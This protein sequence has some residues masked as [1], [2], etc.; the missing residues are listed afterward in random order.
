M[1]KDL[2]WPLMQGVDGAAPFFRGSLTNLLVRCELHQCAG[3]AYL[4]TE[5]SKLANPEHEL[6]YRQCADAAIRVETYATADTLTAQRIDIFTEA[7][8][9]MLWAFSYRP[10][11]D[12][13][14][15]VAR[16]VEG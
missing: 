16:A 13:R 9:R 14:D 4:F 15:T 10:K 5:Y 7:L 6:T 2:L 8:T 3:F 12:F 1:L 11:V